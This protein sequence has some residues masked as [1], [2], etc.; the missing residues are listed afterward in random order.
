MRVHGGFMGLHV[1]VHGCQWSTGETAGVAQ[2]TP[3]QVLHLEPLGSMP[4]S[5]QFIGIWECLLSMARCDLKTKT[6]SASL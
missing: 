1:W 3:E 5:T 2:G 4:V 6:P